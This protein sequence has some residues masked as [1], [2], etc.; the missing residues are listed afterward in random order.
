MILILKII[1]ISN[2]ILFGWSVKVNGH[3]IILTKKIA[4]LTELD[5]DIPNLIAKLLEL[6]DE[7]NDDENVYLI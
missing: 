6:D 4:K 2:A 5:N 1:T 3:K 7:H